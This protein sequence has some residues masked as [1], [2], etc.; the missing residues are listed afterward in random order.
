MLF[1]I[2]FYSMAA[3]SLRVGESDL[4]LAGG[5]N[6][7]FSPSAYVSTAKM[8]AMAVDGHCKTFDARA[9]GLVRGEGCGVLVLKR[10][11]DALEDDDRIHAVI[12]GTAIN[13]DGRTSNMS[14][15]N[16]K[17]QEKVI[18][19]ALENGGLEPEQ[20]SYVEA[21]GTGTPLGDPIEIEA[22]S[23][24]YGRPDGQPLH[25]GAVKSNLGHLEAAAGIAGLIKAVLSVKNGKIAPNLHWESMNPNISL[26]GTRLSLPQELTNWNSSDEPL[27]AGVSAFG[28]GGVNAHIILEEAPEF[29]DESEDDEDGIQ[30]EL[31]VLT[32]KSEEGLELMARSYIDYFKGGN[33]PS[34]NDI[35]Y[36][37]DT[38]RTQHDY[39]LAIAANSP[40]GFL[41]YL[42]PFAKGM[43]STGLWTG[44]LQTSSKVKVAF[45]FSG[46]GPQWWAMGR[47]FLETD[48]IF[49]DTIEE[50]DALLQEH[51][52]EWSLLKELTA[53]EDATRMGETAL[54]QPAIFALQTALARMWIAH[55]VKPSAVVGHSVGEVAA[56]HIGGVIGL[57]EA[58]R[59][60]Y[61]RAL[62]MQKATGLGKMASVD[63][64]QADAEKRIKDYGDRLA[65]A[66]VNAPDSVVLAGE[67][68]ALDE[69]LEQLKA[70][71][72][73]S[74]KLRVN[75]AFHSPQM[76]PFRDE[77]ISILGKVDL[78]S[79]DDYPVYSTLKGK[80][81][82]AS[83]YS[84]EYWGNN[85]RQAVLF[86]DAMSALVK[87]GFNNFLEISP[88][89][90]LAM[91]ITQALEGKEGLVLSSL[92]REKKDREVF[93]G[94]LGALYTAGLPVNWDQV[95]P[96]GGNFVPPP[97]YPWQYERF[98]ADEIDDEGGGG[99][100][101]HPILGQ[102]VKTALKDIIYEK[103]FRL[104]SPPF[105]KDHI[106]YDMCIAP[107]SGHLAML[108]AALRDIHGEHFSCSLDAN[109]NRALIIDEGEK[110]PL[111][112]ILHPEG[113]DGYSFGIYTDMGEAEWALLCEGKVT[114]KILDP[115]ENSAPEVEQ[116]FFDEI[117]E[118]CSE[119]LS[120]DDFYTELQSAG[121]QLGVGFQWVQGDI[122]RTEGEVLGRLAPPDADNNMDLYKIH[123]GLIDSS[124]QFPVSSCFANHLRVGVCPD[125]WSKIASMFHSV[126]K[127]WSI[128]VIP[129]IR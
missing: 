5:V 3:Q 91:N 124:F 116:S 89:P 55:G 75:Y 112:L 115:S 43:Q 129:V 54:A 11:S 70:E 90:A 81:A 122:H 125:Y 88:H 119:N 97:S 7:M 25:V 66:A 62:I 8:L 10:L 128:M 94:S 35:C 27:M 18:L 63:L 118:R 108:F 51:T 36:S 92:H 9:D 95:Y 6:L 34:I 82:K 37:A 24:V 12:R 93:L 71:N 111:Q 87:D 21:H 101:A 77:L 14:A 99:V 60:I 28:A 23:E 79:K 64:K 17:A 48:S 109:V 103:Q 57:K 42:E 33:L 20:V 117:K 31:L 2:G 105:L 39:R 69:I 126:S 53:D 56:A 113:R 102:Q 76:A 50:I 13:E 46:Q 58:V 26:D 22:L 59:I 52:K 68:E 86:A 16:G 98:W 4:A 74:K 85:I 84:A 19:K 73:Q 65:V 80:R 83:D 45:V 30:D 41:S 104:Q 127:R 40:Q 72:V 106:V 114:V 78:N 67:E 96:K 107:A 123:P 47:Q 38:R 61:N 49:R 32:A 100:E 110:S 29:E 120:S 44:R 15:P 1:F 121:Y